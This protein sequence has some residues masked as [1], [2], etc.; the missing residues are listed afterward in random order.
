MGLVELRA[1]ERLAVAA[2]Q[3]RLLQGLA[4]VRLAEHEI[5]VA[6]ARAGFEEPVELA[7]ADPPDFS[8]ADR[9]AEGFDFTC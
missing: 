3:S 7:G 9:V 2:Q 6:L 8:P 4:V 5:V 1:L